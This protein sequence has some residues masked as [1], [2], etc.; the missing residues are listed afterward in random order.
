[1]RR[2]LISYD[3]KDEHDYAALERDLTHLGGVRVLQSVWCLPLI[4]SA[5]SMLNRLRQ[6]VAAD[7]RIIIVEFSV[8]A[9]QNL[10]HSPDAQLPA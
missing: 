10:L 4:S 2:L 9:D 6:H 1:M 3:F 5:D 7:E 8:H